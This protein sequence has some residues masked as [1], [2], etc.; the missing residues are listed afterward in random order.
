MAFVEV[1]SVHLSFLLFNFDQD[2]VY[3]LI[4]EWLKT[5]VQEQFKSGAFRR[6]QMFVGSKHYVLESD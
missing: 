3:L 5:V 1:V 6:F 2:L 4:K